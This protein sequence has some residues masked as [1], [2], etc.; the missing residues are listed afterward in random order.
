MSKANFPIDHTQAKAFLEA[1]APD[2][3]LTFQTFAEKPFK[4]TCK[5]GPQIIHG[6]YSQVCER[7]GRLNDL[8]HGVFFMINQGDLKGRSA[9]NVQRVRAYFIDLDDAPIDPVLNSAL[10]AQILVESSPEKWHAYWITE[11]CPLDEFKP[12]QQALLKRF[13]ADSTAIDLCRVLRLP[14]Y[15]HRKNVPFRTRLATPQQQHT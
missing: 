11:D 4:D 1:L 10:P 6:K 2:D 7:L 13:E 12:R 15:W 5:I 9:K 14:G 8:G 3:Q